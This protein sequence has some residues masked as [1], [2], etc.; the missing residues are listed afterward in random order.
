MNSSLVSLVIPCHNQQHYLSQCIQSI[1]LQTYKD[2]E[3]IV[4]N[5]ASTDCSSEIAHY[6]ARQDHRVHVVSARHRGQTKSL[7][8]AFEMTTGIYI[9]WIDSDDVLALTALEEAVAI[10]E[11]QPEVG[12]VYT[13]YWTIDEQG[14]PKGIGQRCSIPYSKNRL[15]I[16]FMTFHFRL[17]RRTAFEQAGGITADCDFVQ[18][19]DLCLRLSEITEIAHIPEPL[20]YYRVHPQSMSAQ[21][22]LD[23]IHSAEAAVNRALIRRGLSDRYQLQVELNETNGRLASQFKL[24]PKS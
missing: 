1:L 4:W 10:L 8:S 14:Q 13:D 19:Y 24:I 18:D 5:D 17:M 11:A 6:Y 15:L 16:D 7:K 20:Y 9:G 3:L 21:Q 12:L 23:L 2:F 22:S